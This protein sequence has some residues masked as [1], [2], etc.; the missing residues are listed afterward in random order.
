VGVAIAALLIVGVWFAVFGG[1]DAEP[2]RDVPA[3][4]VAPP[5]EPQPQPAES[6]QA[7]PAAPQ[8]GVNLEMVT[9]RPV[10]VRV[11]VDGRRAIERELP[12][13]ERIPLRA[14]HT[15]VIRAGDAGAIAVR[16]G[17]GAETR[18]G[19]N[20]IVATRTFT[21]ERRGEGT[22]GR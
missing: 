4:A 20:G 19:E 12:A 16:R 6:A 22:T 13:G 14:E 18:L 11:T 7:P 17:T 8:T 1:R 2:V 3:G 10:W 5:P 21:A 15:I 9:I